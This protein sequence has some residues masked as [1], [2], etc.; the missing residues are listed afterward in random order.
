MDALLGKKRKEK[1][2]HKKAVKEGIKRAA[3]FEQKGTVMV[4]NPV[5]GR[6]YDV[7]G[8]RYCYCGS[9][10]A[11]IEAGLA[12]TGKVICPHYKA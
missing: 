10:G 6:F 1:K 3:T 7:N 8:L 11:M 4:S 5:S 2:T 9:C 12:G